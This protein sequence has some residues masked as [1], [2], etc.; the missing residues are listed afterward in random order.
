MTR[1]AKTLPFPV[2]LAVLIAGSG[3]SLVTVPVKTAGSI[4]TTTVKTGGSVV[5]APFKAACGGYRCDAAAPD[6]S[7]DSSGREIR[8]AGE[9]DE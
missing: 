5:E 6:G 7:G 3:C 2:L 1:S 8:E 4:V 9:S